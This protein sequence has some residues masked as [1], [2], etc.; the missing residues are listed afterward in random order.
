MPLYKESVTVTNLDTLVSKN[1][2]VTRGMLM[3]W[4]GLT[5]NTN[6]YAANTNLAPEAT[7]DWIK[8]TWTNTSAVSARD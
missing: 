7:L 1:I 2:T 6:A 8:T 4:V 3:G 5:P